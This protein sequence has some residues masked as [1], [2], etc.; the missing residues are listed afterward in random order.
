MYKKTHLAVSG[1]D[2]WW[3]P[4]K[5]LPTLVLTLFSLMELIGVG[6]TKNTPLFSS[7]TGVLLKDEVLFWE[8][9]RFSVAIQSSAWRLLFMLDDVP[10]VDNPVDTLSLFVSTVNILGHDDTLKYSDGSGFSP[11]LNKILINE[12]SIVNL[13]YKAHHKAYLNYTVLQMSST[14]KDYTLNC[15]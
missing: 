13:E 12:L 15:F 4:S 8:G 14:N 9:S 5:F 2:D 6:G 3:P 1:L 11:V 7:L 10:A